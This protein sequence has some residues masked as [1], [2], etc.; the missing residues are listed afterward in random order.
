MKAKKNELL[1]SLG[2]KVVRV[3]EKGTSITLVTSVPKA[4]RTTS[5]TT[6]LEELT[7][8]PKR[9]RTLVKGKEKVGSQKSNVQDDVGILLVKAHSAVTAKDLKALSGVPSNELLNCHIH[10]PAQ[11]NLFS[12]CIS[13]SLGWFSLFYSSSLLMSFRHQER[14]S[15]YL[16]STLA[17]RRRPWWQGPK[18]RLQ[19][20]RLRN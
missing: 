11:V 16:L 15:I 5:S 18:W 4:T 2:K 9:Q 10:K 20:L 8:C 13:Y 3:V 1:S 17:R 7:P 19:G 6:S 12:F 14:Q